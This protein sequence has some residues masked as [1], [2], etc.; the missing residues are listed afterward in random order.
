MHIYQIHYPE[1]EQEWVAWWP[2]LDT[3]YLGL[4]TPHLG[5]RGGMARACPQGLRGGWGG[6]PLQTLKKHKNRDY[7]M[8]KN[9]IRVCSEEKKCLR[10]A[11]WPQKAYKQIQDVFFQKKKC[12]R[13]AYWPQTTYMFCFGEGIGYWGG[14]GEGLS[15]D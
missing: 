10:Q 15:V 4:I 5:P 2:S 13:Q 12:L 8:S 11:Y 9:P 1:A 7:G 14:D 6:S 3:L